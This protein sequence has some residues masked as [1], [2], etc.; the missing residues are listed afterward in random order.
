MTEIW[1]KQR[2]IPFDKI[3]VN[4]ERVNDAKFILLVVK[5]LVGANHVGR[6]N[7]GHRNQELINGIPC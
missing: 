6:K 5:K 7:E 4:G 1:Q 2:F 3:F